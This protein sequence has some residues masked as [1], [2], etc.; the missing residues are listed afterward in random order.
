[1]A[2]NRC[3]GT[4]YCANNCP[5]KVRRFNYFNYNQEVGVGYGVKAYP[6]SIES[7]SRQLQALV[8]NPEVTVRGR[9]VMEK[10]TYCV[11]RIEGAKI[12][13]RKDGGRPVADGEIV[14]ACQSACPTNAIEFGNVADPNSKVSKKHADVRSYGML[15]QLNIKPRT[16]YLARVRNPHVRLMTRNQLV[17]LAEM[18]SPHHGHEGHGDHKGHGEGDHH[19]SDHAAAAKHDENHDKEHGH[20]DDHEPKK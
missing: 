18:K 13:A 8:L 12:N 15:G 3:I 5:F 6:S 16:E 2:Y 19:D 11:Q 17:D 9:G 1:M 4:R 7:A 14:T 20:D 10:C